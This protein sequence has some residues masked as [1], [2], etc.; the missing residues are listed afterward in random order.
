MSDASLDGIA[1]GLKLIDIWR[2]YHLAELNQLNLSEELIKSAQTFASDD[3]QGHR[4]L[5][6]LELL[7]LIM[8]LRSR[9]IDPETYP[10]TYDPFLLSGRL[11]IP[12]SYVAEQLMR[13]R[14]QGL[15]SCANRNGYLT[16]E[17]SLDVLGDMLLGYRL[18]KLLRKKQQEAVKQEEP[19][20]AHA[21]ALSKNRSNIDQLLAEDL[22][23]DELLENLADLTKEH[24]GAAKPKCG[25]PQWHINKASALLR[26]AVSSKDYCE[27]L[28]RTGTWL[29]DSM[30]GDT[31]T[32][33]EFVRFLRT[34]KHHKNTICSDIEYG[35]AIRPQPGIPIIM[36][37]KL[38]IPQA[39]RAKEYNFLIT[40]LIGMDPDFATFTRVI[41]N[42]NPLALPMFTP[43]GGLRKRIF[44]F[45]PSPTDSHVVLDILEKRY[46]YL[47]ST[48]RHRGKH[49][50]AVP[51][52]RELENNLAQMKL[53]KVVFDWN[54]GNAR[55][56]S[57]TRTIIRNLDASGIDELMD[58]AK[59]LDLSMWNISFDNYAVFFNS[60]LSALESILLKE[61][62]GQLN[63]FYDF[64]PLKGKADMKLFGDNLQGGEQPMLDLKVLGHSYSLNIS[65]LK[66][67]LAVDRLFAEND[68]HAIA[69]DSL[70]DLIEFNREYIIK[71]HIGLS[72]LVRKAYEVTHDDELPEPWYKLD[73]SKHPLNAK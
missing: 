8:R 9:K 45:I 6:G 38:S 58:Y 12:P 1:R 48:S 33:E 11:A 34:Q 43:K 61:L 42:D 25:N 16:F 21:P 29:D 37:Y 52:E 63:S 69:A 36:F 57:E 60:V 2:S 10:G 70:K 51:T 15:V 55:R 41:K 17:V 67:M 72:E 19:A 23:D 39:T 35:I 62:S 44:L 20:Q 30:T 47:L 32:L 18:S 50:A 7:N 5:S 46:S 4:E 54:E 53:A 56:C 3:G 65:M 24:L 66:R 22:L 59:S 40:T 28:A 71:G 27:F 14:H 73:Y 31:G 64:K 68:T 13:F 49:K 26:R